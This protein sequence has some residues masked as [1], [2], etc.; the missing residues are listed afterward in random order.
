MLRSDDALAGARCCRQARPPS[1]IDFICS[2]DRSLPRSRRNGARPKRRRQAS[3]GET[4][5]RGAQTPAVQQKIANRLGWLDSPALM[6]DSLARLQAFADGDR[7]RRLHRR[8]A[9]RHGRVEPRARS[10]AR[11]ARR[12]DRLAASAHARFDRSRRRARSGDAA[13]SARC[14]SSP[15]S[16]ARRSSR[17]SLAAHFRARSK[18]RG[19]AATGRSTSSRSPIEGTELDRR[20][21]AEGFRDVFINPADIGGRYSALSFFGLVPAA[22]MGLDIAALVGGA[23]RCSRRRSQAWA[24]RRFESVGRAGTGDWRRRARR[25]ATS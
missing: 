24:T 13:T 1:R 22:L 5:R 3:G 19:V 17:T 11:G 8:R 12:R 23:S 14:I 25:A 7:A 20:A 21:R 10:A 2:P 9:A 6:A 15:A 18:R 4:R 16:R